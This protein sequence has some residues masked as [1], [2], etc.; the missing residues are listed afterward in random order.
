VLGIVPVN[1]RRWREHETMLRHIQQIGAEH[2]L[3][4]LDPVPNSRAVLRYSLAGG[5]WRQ[6]AEALIQRESGERRAT[7]ARR[8]L[9]HA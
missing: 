2:D 9:V 6:V 7:E 5:L 1:V 4:V 3:R 8:A